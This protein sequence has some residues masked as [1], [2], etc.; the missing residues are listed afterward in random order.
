MVHLL[1]LGHIV[2]PQPGHIQPQ[3][4]QL[5]LLRLELILILLTLLLLLHKCLGYLIARLHLLPQLVL[6][7][8]LLEPQLL[9]SQL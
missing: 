8:G 7:L 2:R 6:L 5:I 3:R 1:L 9:L 4:S